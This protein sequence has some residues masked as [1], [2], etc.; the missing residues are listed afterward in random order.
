MEVVKTSCEKE[1]EVF[2]EPT[3]YEL[4]TLVC[5]KCGAK[6]HFENQHVHSSKGMGDHYRTIHCPCCLEENVVKSKFD[7]GSYGFSNT[8]EVIEEGNFF[9]ELIC[10]DCSTIIHYDYRDVST[11]RVDDE[12]GNPTYIRG[13]VCPTCGKVLE[14]SKEMQ[15]GLVTLEG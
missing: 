11:R 2:K 15:K 1:K 7:D 3:N 4:H 5:E 8:I 13:I 12:D 10:D 14:A 6:L 9:E